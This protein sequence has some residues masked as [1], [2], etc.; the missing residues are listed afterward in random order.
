MRLRDTFAI[1]LASLLR[2]K[3]RAVLTMLGIVIGVASVILML[4]VGQAAQRFILSQVASFG[5]DMIFIRNGSGVQAPGP[6][7]LMKQSL[8]YDDYVRLKEQSWVKSVTPEVISPTLVESPT[9]SL[10]ES[11]TGVAES[12][13]VIF[14]AALQSGTYLTSDQVDSRARV[15]VLGHDLAADLFGEEDPV[16]KSVKILKK[17]YRV[18]G[19]LEPAGTKFFTNLDRV[20]YIPVT[21]LMQELNMQYV[22]FI[23]LKAGDTPTAQAQENIRIILRVTHKLD[24]PTGDLAK[25]D[26]AVTTQE[27]TAKRAGTIGTILSVLLSS[28]AGISLVVGGVGIMNIMYVTVTE[29]TREIGLRKAVGARSRDVM[30]QFLSEAI[31]LTVI[32]GAIGVAIGVSLSWLGLKVLSSYQSGWSFAVPWNAVALGFSVSALIGIVFGYFPARRAANL[33][34]IEALR[35]E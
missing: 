7:Q 21:T 2:N 3:R 15:V 16:G 29:R 33:S 32:A 24:N 9:A 28:I 27:D 12:A 17:N 14:D 8:T 22:Q 25:D 4:S 26:F 19:V 30:R 6:P 23:A 13:I 1:S 31:F 18:V 5:S 34:P 20:L 11:V 35:Y 10:H